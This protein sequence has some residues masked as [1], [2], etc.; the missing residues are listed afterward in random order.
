MTDSAACLPADLAGEHQIR[1]VPLRVLAG[2]QVSDDRTG[3]DGLAGDLMLRGE[4]LTTAR[5][6][7]ETFA[8]VY[9]QAE[10]AGASAVVSV[11]L[12]GQLSGTVSSAE[13]AAAGAALSVLVVDSRSIGMGLGLAVL[14]AAGAAAAGLAAEHVAKAAVESAARTG[15]FFALD[16]PR[17]LLAG[18]RLSGAGGIGAPALVSRPLLAIRDSQITMLERVR[19]RSAA[20]DR[21]AELAAEFAAGRAVDLAIG[22]TGNAERAAGLAGRLARIIPRSRKIYLAEASTAI[23]VHTGPGMLGVA[24][25][26]C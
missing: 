1:V 26:P 22:H 20:A 24:I 21:L 14:A 3:L 15:S 7:P 5:P 11:H 12:S 10:A 25:S 18:G 6:A 19:T 2:G 23:G 16:S 9:R 17:A 4:R 13:S 8:L